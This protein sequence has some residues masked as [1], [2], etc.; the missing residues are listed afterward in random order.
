M[1]R[2]LF[3][4]AVQGSVSSLVVLLQED[5]LIL[6]RVIVNCFNETPLH[7]AA[8][9]GHKDFVNEILCRKPE[10]AREVN[11]RRS[12]PLHLASAKGYVEI[13]QALLSVNSEMCLARDRDGR[14]P[15][16][17]AAI[18]GHVDVL[19]ELVRAR[20]HAARVTVEYSGVTILH[21]CVNH[22]QLEALKLLVETLGSDEFV[23][24][25]DDDGNTILHLAVA[26]KQIQTINFLLTSSTIEVNA[27][28]AN[29]FTAA[30]VLAQSRRDVKDKNIIESLKRA[31]AS[32][33]EANRSSVS[34]FGTKM[35]TSLS[36]DTDYRISSPHPLEKVWE[37]YL[38]K[39]DNWL[40]KTRNTLMVVASL[41]ATMAFQVGVNPPGGVWQDDPQAELLVG[42]EQRFQGSEYFVDQK[43]ALFKGELG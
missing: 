15:L 7:V 5:P 3:E 23:N 30:D 13:V 19:K 41:I 31:G 42:R 22:N 8:M 35:N 2:K 37:K 9:L 14:N 27:T 29:G 17:L 28:N 21:L 24:S 38:K 10:L 16:H 11:S 36:W 6:D 4:A 20:P 12:S 25:K 26:D 33:A 18:K 43:L 1:E 32:G 40:E 39:Q 34:E